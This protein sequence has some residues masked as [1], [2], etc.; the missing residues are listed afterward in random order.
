MEVSVSQQPRP[1]QS[2]PILWE[3]SIAAQGFVTRYGRLG[4]ALYKQYLPFG[5]ED[6][7]AHPPKKIDKRLYALARLKAIQAEGKMNLPGG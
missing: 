6:R 2:L 5:V 3:F 7:F 1:L 4:D